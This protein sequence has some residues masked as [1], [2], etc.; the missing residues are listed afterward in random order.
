MPREPCSRPAKEP[1]WVQMLRAP[2][3]S[4]PTSRQGLALPLPCRQSC[5]FSSLLLKGTGEAPLSSFS[6]TLMPARRGVPKGWEAIQRNPNA[7]LPLY[8]PQLTEGRSKSFHHST[9][10]LLLSSAQPSLLQP[11]PPTY[12]Y[13]KT[14]KSG[15]VP[16]TF[17]MLAV[18]LSASSLAA[19]SAAV[20]SWEFFRGEW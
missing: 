1:C 2:F 5:G 13:G 6:S 4:C 12:V 18:M 17:R 9:T 10:F 14:W 19:L 8:R 11:S 7:Q 20:Y 15:S 16:G 3:S